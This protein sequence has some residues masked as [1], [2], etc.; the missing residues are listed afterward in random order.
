MRIIA[1]RGR[2][3][4]LFAPKGMDTR[5]TQD[6]VKESLF[7]MIQ[8]DVPQARVLD[9]FAGS[10]ALALESLSR[11]AESA[12]LVDKSR[13][14]L[15]CIRRNIQKLRMDDETTVL[16]CDWTQALVKCQIQGLQFDLVFLDPPYRMTE[17]A[18][19]SNKLLEMNLLA[20]DALLVIE[21]RTDTQ[22][23]MNDCFSLE[24]ERTYGDTQIHFYR[25]NMEEAHEI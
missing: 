16:A 10:G 25:L 2:G 13:E 17:L 11:G 19:I 9:L 18:E 15:D 20:Q 5:P 12:V 22:P 6:K 14:A 1:G 23:Q 7:N 4:Q 24:R 3:T 21:H 8:F